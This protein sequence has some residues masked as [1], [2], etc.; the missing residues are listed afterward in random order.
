M[1]RTF[2]IVYGS[3]TIGNNGT[4]S[5]VRLDGKV[6]FE[7]SYTEVTVSFEVIVL[8]SSV[9]AFHTARTALVNAYTTPDQALELEVGGADRWA[10][11]QAGNTGFNAQPSIEEL[12]GVES[13]DRSARFRCSVTMG[14]PATLTGKDG[15]QS[16]SV[17]VAE[18][19]AGYRTVTIAGTYTALS[20]NGARAQYA[21]SIDTYVAAVK[22]A[23]SVSEWDLVGT[24]SADTDD[25]DKVLV[26]S[27]TYAEVRREQGVGVTNV[28][29][30][31]N[32]Q[33]RIRQ[34]DTATNATTEL[35]QSEPLRTLT[36]TYAAT[37]HKD[38]STNVPEFYESTIRPKIIEELEALGGG[39]VIVQS[40]DVDYGLTGN[41]VAVD[42]VVQ[43]DSGSGLY[44]ARIVVE[45]FTIS[46]E[47]RYPIWNGDPYSRDVY[48][49]LGLWT[50]TVTKTVLRRVGTGASLVDDPSGELFRLN[51]TRNRRET[52][53][54]GR[55]TETQLELEA[56]EVTQELERVNSVR[57]AAEFGQNALQEF[58]DTVSDFSANLAGDLF[59]GFGA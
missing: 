14:R 12:D 56:V 39:G 1:A 20:G 49:G 48:D 35:G 21:A 37:V 50:R 28:D 23:L 13:T 38:T 22:L 24:P 54:F 45:D 59:G 42:M 47:V 25:N 34:R 57:S 19:A 52:F 44:A 15:R 5:D 30:L 17:S 7:Q 31:I 29:G 33:L 3:Y 46:G 4:S 41:D 27:R 32:P 53:T 26:F 40:E 16:S 55:A 51:W 10:F 6:S 9:S 18:D 43:V 36:V 58:A 2:E 8:S 11:T